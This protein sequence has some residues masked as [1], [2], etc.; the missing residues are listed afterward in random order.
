MNNSE[1]KVANDNTEEHRRIAAVAFTAFLL[2]A[3]QLSAE[4][5]GTV[6]DEE[7]R[8]VAAASVTALP[9]E[10]HQQM[11]ARQLAGTA[12][13]AAAQT[14]SDRDGRFAIAP[15]LPVVDLFVTADGFAPAMLRTTQD[16]IGVVRIQ[17]AALRRGRITSGHQPLAGVTIIARGPTGAELIAKSAADG[18]YA[19][20]DPALWVQTLTLRHP[21]HAART[22]SRLRA[23]DS[24]LVLDQELSI[25]TPVSGRIDSAAALDV[26]GWPLG[27]TA[28]DG[29]FAIEHPPE[30]ARPIIASTPSSA[31]FVDLRSGV[32]TLAPAAAIGGTTV[33]ATEVE[34][35]DRRGMLLRSA[36]ADANGAW[37]IASLPAGNYQLTALRP[38]YAFASSSLTL[39]AGNEQHVDPHATQ[40][41]RVSGR[42]TDAKGIAVASACITAMNEPATAIVANSVSAP[43]GRYVIA[44]LPAS[45]SIRLTVTKS[46]F[47]RGSSPLLAVHGGEHRTRTDIVLRRGVDVTARVRDQEQRAISGATL[48]FTHR[49]D[50]SLDELFPGEV[51]TSAD[52]VASATMPRGR[53][54]IRVDA[55]GFATAQV[56]TNITDEDANLD[57]IMKPAVTLTG[58]VLNAG[59]P[60][61]E[62]A[63]RV[64]DATDDALATTDRDGRFTLRN[65]AAGEVKLSLR[66]PAALI[67]E[68]RD[69]T[70]P[71]DITIELESGVSISGSVINA[72]T[73]KAIRAFEL[74]L[75]RDEASPG[76]SKR[77]TSSDGTFVLERVAP[78]TVTIT[79]S[80]DGYAQMTSAP[81]VVEQQAIGDVK[82]ELSGGAIVHG[83]V[84][85]DG[86][87]P[88]G[89]AQVAVLAGSTRLEATTDDKGRYS[90]A[91]VPFGAA[92]I[93]VSTNDYLTVRDELTV[94][95]AT[96]LHDVR[97]QAGAELS[98]QVVD[99][100]GAVA[101]AQ[102]TVVSEAETTT[103]VSAGDGTFRFRSLHRGHYAVSAAKEGFA[104]SA[105]QEV[106]VPSTALV[107][108]RLARGGTLVGHVN[109]IVSGV[110]VTVVA[111]GSFG[112][113][114]AHT[115]AAGDFR[116]ESMVPGRASIAAHMDVNGTLHSTRSVVIEVIAGAEVRVELG[117]WEQP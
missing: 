65:L 5:S 115:D 61:D 99:N 16:E 34:L 7:G 90:I 33:A 11:T 22:L 42:I 94:D 78:G 68:Q 84:I 73:K 50:P 100:D 75:R 3:P 67:D 1:L 58:R 107:T 76:T 29:T 14:T 97:L 56:E 35:R 101:G 72:S 79:A 109:G 52:G 46:G 66:K 80:A 19:L 6:V 2:V 112:I 15:E 12:R 28:A 31:A 9:L 111:A 64:V 25:G 74:T 23:D 83:T 54:R 95:A 55:P 57:I 77:F 89:G 38:G 49:D 116:I 4:V 86:G 43:D 106:D 53:Y 13:T 114:V 113:E 96:T 26:D 110:D 108:L 48:R 104:R 27:A 69:V 82:L 103:A 63:I 30:P 32:T 102:V 51:R 45:D 8:A 81:I 93:T 20:P 18:S 37:R 62:V 91:A 17:H 44:A 10:T 92:V 117:E 88:A 40:L 47:E 98:G 71:G 60:V 24:P 85:G 39:V 105:P 21:A 41:A 59:Q 70:A 87:A 36:I